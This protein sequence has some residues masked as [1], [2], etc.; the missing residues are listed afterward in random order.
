VN[1]HL[2]E[3]LSA[4]LDGE[5]SPADREAAEAHLRDCAACTREL[6]ELA[7]VDAL[8][9][10]WPVEAPAGYFDELPGRVR[11][12]VRARRKP[13]LAPAAV[14][15]TAAAAVVMFALVTPLALRQAP[16]TMPAAAPVAPAPAA[17]VPEAGAIARVPLVT[18]GPRASPVP[19]ALGALEAPA[20][21]SERDR[22]AKAVAASK[23]PALSAPRAMDA[24]ARDKVAANSAV[25]APAAPPPS[26]ATA[27][28]TPPAAAAAESRA[29]GAVAPTPAQEEQKAEARPQQ[30]ADAAAPMAEKRK[31]GDA[32]AA[33]RE[34]A[35]AGAGYERAMGRRLRADERYEML[36]ARR[37]TTAA[38]ARALAKAWEAF[39]RDLPAGRHA[40]EARVRAIESAVTAWRLGGEPGD[41]ESARAAARAYLGAESAPQR[42]RVRTLLET[43]PPSE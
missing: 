35:L 25:P 12:R 32:T 5:M 41:L 9:R 18:E 30:V 43:L 21:V 24:T 6:E 26:F 42:D 2:G 31:E 38:D 19:D 11:A 17:V 10:E 14:W 33:S 37:P 29:A 22:M 27:P 34:G 7:S 15:A 3:R 1:G 8:A 36:L 20:R 28:A 4:L 39:A 40:D 13:R 16:S 23:P